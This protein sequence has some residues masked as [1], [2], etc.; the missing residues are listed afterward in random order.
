MKKLFFVLCLLCCAVFAD[1][2]ALVKNGK[3]VS[4]IVIPEK[5]TRSVQMAAF[6]LQ[7]LVQ[8]IT[9]A[10]LTITTRSGKA[11]LPVYLGPAKEDKLLEEWKEK[12]P[13]D[14]VIDYL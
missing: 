3:P 10:E 7:H 9:G 11:M 13:N 5:P 1:E 2:I 4:E 6:E 14:P 12:H 8:L